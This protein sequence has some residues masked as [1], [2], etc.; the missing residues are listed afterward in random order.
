MNRRVFTKIVLIFFLCLNFLGI[1]MS[2]KID[3]TPYVSTQL[4][5][6]VLLEQLRDFLVIQIVFF[7]IVFIPR[8]RSLNKSLLWCLSAIVPVLNI[9]FCIYLCIKK[10]DKD[11]IK[12]NSLPTRKGIKRIPYFLTL[13]LII[14]VYRFF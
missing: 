10:S 3:Y 13:L 1:I 2:S 12:E 6:S 9:F 14:F 8:L 7:F 4:Y 5:F 11:E